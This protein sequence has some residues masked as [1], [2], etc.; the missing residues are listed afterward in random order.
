M[1]EKEEESRKRIEE[2][3]RTR[4]RDITSDKFGQQTGE[5]FTRDCTLRKI[6]AAVRFSP[7]L[8]E[9]FGEKY[10]SLDWDS[11]S[12]ELAVLNSDSPDTAEKE[13]HFL[14]GI[15]LFI[16][17]SVFYSD[18]DGKNFS[19]LMK[20]LRDCQKIED[21]IDEEI[22]ESFVDD[23]FQTLYH[24]LYYPWAMET[25]IDLISF[26]NLEYTSY[27][28]EKR[29]SGRYSIICDS[30]TTA[31]E[32]PARRDIS[33]PVRKL[34]DSVIELVPEREREDAEE[35]FRELFYRLID[36][37]LEGRI[38]FE[39]QKTKLDAQEEYLDYQMDEMRGRLDK[40]SA[41]ERRAILEKMDDLDRKRSNYELSYSNYDDCYTDGSFTEP[42]LKDRY[43]SAFS[44]IE[45][46]DPYKVV[47]GFFFLLEKGDDM[48]WM[49]SASTATLSFAS[50]LLPW[51]ETEW[52]DDCIP[53]FPE[54]YHS[55]KDF[56]KP[57]LNPED[58]GFDRYSFPTLSAAKY[59]FLLTD[60]VPPRYTFSFPDRDKV[61][62]VMGNELTLELEK[63]Y[64]SSYHAVHRASYDNDALFNS[65][66]E[67]MHEIRAL[68]DELARLN[69]KISLF[70]KE[71]SEGLKTD[72]NTKKKLRDELDS[73][74]R[75][76][77]KL[78]TMRSGAEF[79]LEKAKMEI[80]RLK[81][82]HRDEKEELNT[83]RELIFENRNDENDRM[84]D[85][86]SHAFTWPYETVKNTVV[87]GGHPDWI[88]KV[89][90]L[91]PTVRFYGDRAPDR[92]SL[93]H[94]DVLWFQTK[95]C[96]SH[97][98]FYKV[99]ET[100]KSLGIPI[101]YCR[102]FGIFSSAEAIVRNDRE[103]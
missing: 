101:R 13:S 50:K 37:Y 45:V 62:A 44:T 86:D 23:H 36:V 72:E 49:L 9:R 103:Q 2:I 64:L 59:I 34:F 42:S 17:D 32:K 89:R 76:I 68:K 65:Y 67:N 48:I 83:L 29:G 75:A 5:V 99:I 74:A 31:F 14:Y 11:I 82:E 70:E 46:P 80:A 90:S 3:I 27:R 25:M 8:K 1:Q 95:I 26:R 100:A 33:L 79:E 77:D 69:E 66:L 47:A 21:N 30:V 6:N 22:Y 4:T 63:S 24:P 73:A 15:A 87:V 92:E 71:K 60:A 39:K 43:S 54:T 41:E 57:L 35:A 102:S 10:P 40:T 93:K 56:Y 97:P 78:E 96:L 55:P 52:D 19:R 61:S 84:D 28:K 18:E 98:T 85:E 38:I 12:A 88:N 94:T 58:V 7:I 53:E 81:S 16:L 51:D 20:I 91:L